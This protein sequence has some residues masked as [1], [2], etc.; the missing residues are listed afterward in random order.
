MHFCF[1][2]IRG[3]FAFSWEGQCV[4]REWRY[5]YHLEE[6]QSSCQWIYNS[7][8][9]HCQKPHVDANSRNQ[10][11]SDGYVHKSNSACVSILIKSTLY[12]YIIFKCQ[13]SLPPTTPYQWP[14]SIKMV[15]EMKLLFI[16]ATKKDVST[17]RTDQIWTD[18]K[19]LSE[20]Y[21]FK[22]FTV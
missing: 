18:F 21:P 3:T 7:L 12:I 4:C 15:L 20:I 6:A 13:V 14:H 9:Q 5:P 8:E 10:F 2:M 11:H 17:N 22:Q 1:P 19:W 16:T